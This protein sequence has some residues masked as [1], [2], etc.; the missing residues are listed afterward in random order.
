MIWSTKA[1]KSWARLSATAPSSTMPLRTC[2][3]CPAGWTDRQ[4][5]GRYHLERR[6]DGA[7]F[8]FAVGPQSWK[9][10][11]HPPVETLLTARNGDDGVTVTNE[12][13]KP[14]RFAKSSACGPARSTPSASRIR[15]FAK[16]RIRMRLTS[17]G[18]AMH[19]SLLSIVVR[20]EALASAFQCRWGRKVDA[21]FDLALTQLVDENRHE[22]LVEVG[23]EGGAEILGHVPHRSGTAAQVAAAEAVVT[24]TASQ[25]GRALET[26]GI[27]ALLLDNLNHPRWDEVAERCLTCAQLHHGVPDLFLHH[28]GGPPILPADPPRAAKVG[29]LLHDGFL[30]HPWWQRAR[31]RE[32]AVPAMD[33]AQARH[34][35]RSIRRVGCVGCGRCITWCP[36]G[37]DIT[38]EAA[39]IRANRQRTKGKVH[40]GT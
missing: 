39:A 21:G 29:F 10:F 22:F 38:E 11:L 36:V 8:G 5:A 1:I 16:G 3:I 9:Q 32:L 12:R 6:E 15:F 30:P 27:K 25:M 34:V 17:C 28:G 18:A 23:S 37:I 13:T 7:L 19:L 2:T 31:D 24:R 14:P 20:P 40:G 4:D 33:D 26:D 35:D